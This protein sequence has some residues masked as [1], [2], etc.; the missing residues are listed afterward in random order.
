MPKART[1]DHDSDQT[2]YRDVIVIR[3]DNESAKSQLARESQMSFPLNPYL[4][5]TTHWRILIGFLTAMTAFAL[6]G[7][8]Q[9]SGPVEQVIAHVRNEDVT[10]K[11]LENELRWANVP[12]DLQHDPEFVKPVLR[13]L[14]VR[15]YWTQKAVE[16][17]VD[18]ESQNALDLMRSRAQ[19]L[20]N[21][22]IQ[23]RAAGTMASKS[24]IDTYIKSNPLKFAQRKILTVEQVSIP[25]DAKTRST[26]EATKHFSTLEQIEQTLTDLG[27]PH[28]RSTGTLSSA[29]FSAELSKRIQANRAEDIYFIHVGGN[30]VFFKVVTEEDSPLTGDASV[31]LAR[32]LLRGQAIENEIQRATAEA[33]AATTFEGEYAKLMDGKLAMTTKDQ[34]ETIWKT[35]KGMVPHFLFLSAGLAAGY[36]LREIKSRRRRAAAKRELASE[37][38]LTSMIVGRR[39]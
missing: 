12:S 28:R 35:G 22:M 9:A 15:K 14:L 31:K 7:C 1:G 21:A 16:A 5:P 11:E 38:A 34:Q 4:E 13:D 30:G 17:G 24:E 26:T 23:R 37:S 18:Q 29:E 8:E 10:L 6:G 19:I 3:P 36:G 2:L 27:I 25:I 32:Q 33:Q 20:G 39:Q